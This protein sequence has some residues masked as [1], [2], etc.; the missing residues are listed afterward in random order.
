ML[1]D[2]VRN[3]G[4]DGATPGAAIRRTDRQ[5]LDDSSPSW[6]TQT[7][8]AAIKHFTF[9][10][11][12]PKIFYVYP[13]ALAG[14]QVEIIDAALPAAVTDETGSLDIGAEYME[15]V[16]NYVAYRCL[17]K[18]SEYANGAMV[19]AYFQAFENALGVKTATEAGA[20]PNQPGNSV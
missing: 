18:D 13:P 11:R 3:M 9:D 10:D 16:A 20:S 7:K 15:A 2:V 6:H 17:F 5:Q 4:M 8:K 19:A 14:T 12:T 1:I